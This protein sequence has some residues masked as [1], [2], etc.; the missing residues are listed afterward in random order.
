MRKTNNYG[1]NRGLPL[2]WEPYLL[3]PQAN[4]LRHPIGKRFGRNQAFSP[5]EK[6]MRLTIKWE[7]TVRLPAVAQTLSESMRQVADSHW[8]IADIGL[9]IE[10]L[11]TALVQPIP[12][13]RTVLVGLAF[14]RSELR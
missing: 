4:A 3:Q 11:L 8:P 13:T 5:H 12:S 7:A 1:I 9:I 14:C 6:R 10:A 2:R